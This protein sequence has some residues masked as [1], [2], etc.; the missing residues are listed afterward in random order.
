MAE[1][2]QRVGRSKRFMR[3]QVNA[4]KLTA[5]KIGGR[6]EYFTRDEYIDAWVESQAVTCHV[7]GLPSN[8][9]ASYTTTPTGSGW[10][11]WVRDE[12][13]RGNAST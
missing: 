1:A 13:M 7:G 4:G 9:A 10:A 3:A 12:P 5:A 2:G 11:L 6:G 8:G